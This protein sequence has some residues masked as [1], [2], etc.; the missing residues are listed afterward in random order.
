MTSGYVSTLAGS[1]YGGQCSFADGYKF[2]ARFYYPK[3]V[4]T[5]SSGDVLVS[6]WLNCAVRR[7]TPS[8]TVTTLLGDGTNCGSSN[9]PLGTASVYFAAG[10]A[11]DAAGNVFIA[12]T[13]NNAVRF[14]TGGGPGVSSAATIDI[15]AGDP[16][17]ASGSSD[18]VAATFN[19]PESVA[20]GRTGGSLYVLD[21]GNHLLRRVVCP[22]LSPSATPTPSL[23]RSY[24]WSSSPTPS[25]SA[26]PTPLFADAFF[27]AAAPPVNC[28]D[29]CALWSNLASDSNTRAQASVDAKWQSGA[30][31]PSGAARRCAAPGRD[32]GGGALGWCYCKGT[33]DSSWGYCVP[34]SATPTV[35]PSQTPTAT[36]LPVRACLELYLAVSRNPSWSSANVVGAFDGGAWSLWPMAL[37]PDGAWWFLKLNSVAALQFALTNDA[38]S[39]WD[40]Q[41]DPSTNTFVNYIAR[42]NGGVYHLYNWGIYFD[43]AEAPACL[44]PSVSS[45]AT[46]PATPSATATATGA[47]APAASP[48]SGAPSAA[49]ATPSPTAAGALAPGT[50]CAFNASCASGACLGSFCCT[51]NAARQ[52]CG[53]CHFGTGTCVLNSPGDSC[54]SA[55]DCGTNLC[56]GGCCCASS[57]LLVAGCSACGC[58]SNASTTAASAGAC[59]AG[60]A[61]P[62]PPPVALQCNATVAL[63]SSVALNRVI[64]FPSGANV[65]DAAPLM[66]LPAASPLNPDGLDVIVATAAACRAFAALPGS[67]QCAART[68]FLEGSLYYYLGAAS[69]LGM[70]AAPACSS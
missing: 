32:P 16:G 34:P 57:A 42:A 6:D 4:A 41:W 18:G 21:S 39:D 69:A 62:P 25:A 9:G 64:S 27:D 19:A 7:I 1:Q 47:A 46:P 54:A 61:L 26:T 5:L 51:R 15:Y 45:T 63:N 35:S 28:F 68:F 37:T 40:K 23:T 55:A 17:G 66:F 11:G 36:P 50:P 65:T 2:D 60:A 12:D 10:I 48:S 70:T 22:S 59:A 49:A 67:A 58:W 30:A 56:L 31:A 3:G 8:G 53:A 38:Q 33:G 52:G 20:L 24:T 44:S 13:G 43:A 14:A 29:G